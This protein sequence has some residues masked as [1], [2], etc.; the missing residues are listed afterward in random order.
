VRITSIPLLLFL[1]YSSSCNWPSCSVRIRH[2]TILSLTLAFNNISQ[3]QYVYISHSKHDQ[4]LFGTDKNTAIAGVLEHR[5][6]TTI[7]SWVAGWL[8][9]YYHSRV[10]LNYLWQEEWLSSI[11]HDVAGWWETIFGKKCTIINHDKRIAKMTPTIQIPSW[12]SSIVRRLFF[13]ETGILPISYKDFGD[14]AELNSKETVAWL[15]GIERIIAFWLDP[16]VD[17]RDDLFS[18]NRHISSST[19]A[20]GRWQWRIIRKCILYQ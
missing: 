19:Y 5:F 14:N 20:K 17:V 8:R 10:Q 12:L 13:S 6:S 18:C 16:I 9:W 7:S 1:S 2:S 4:S 3:S 15:K 11:S